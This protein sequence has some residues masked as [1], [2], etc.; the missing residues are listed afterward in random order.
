[1]II[2]N[3]QQHK[4]L[5]LELEERKFHYQLLHTLFSGPMKSETLQRWNEADFQ[6]VI[7]TTGYFAPFLSELTAGHIDEIAEKEQESYLKLF[8][9]PGHIPAPPWE[10]VYR[11]NDKALFGEPTLKLRAKL[12]EFQL[13][14]DEE[15]EMPE[16]HIAIE[17]EFM[18]FLI[19]S[20]IAALEGQK[21]SQF[22]KSMYYQFLLLDDH[23]VQW[24]KPFSKD[25]LS[26]TTSSLYSG[27]AQLIRD[28]VIEDSK[29]MKQIEE[30][31]S[32][33]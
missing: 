16:D 7:Q 9:G 3:S 12:R 21:Q 2:V 30:V 10:S 20:A 15:N 24:V 5:Q 29:Y 26:H 6:E 27:A 17:L 4:K 28:F 13:Q 31:L 8:F 25:I 19:D 22:N 32:H 11:T 1:M 33:V 18:V 23:L 14:S